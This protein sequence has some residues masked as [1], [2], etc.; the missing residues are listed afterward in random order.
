MSLRGI[1]GKLRVRRQTRHWHHVVVT[2]DERDLGNRP[3]LAKVLG[4]D[5]DEA[6]VGPPEHDPRSCEVFGCEC[7][8]AVANGGD[9]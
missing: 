5:D 3:G 7:R 9:R 6:F 2:T 1:S 8:H 4:F